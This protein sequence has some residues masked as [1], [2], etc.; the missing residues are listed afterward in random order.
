MK[1]K[2]ILIGASTG[3]PGH[4]KK[5]LCSLPSSFKTPII[6]AQHMNKNFMESFVK[7]FDSELPNKVFL[8]DSSYSIE[9]S[10]IYICSKHCELTYSLNS[11]HIECAQDVNSSFNPSVEHL[12]NSAIGLINKIQITAILLTGIGS[13]GALAMSNLQKSGVR[14][15]AESEK[16]AIVFGMPKRA[17]ELN[18]NIKALDLDEIIEYIKQFEEE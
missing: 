6:I 11:M 14:C 9:S 2:L 13:D 16:S 3:G 12:F 1:Q 4:L 15:I 10:S 17:L 18:A 7:Q 8:V 5:I